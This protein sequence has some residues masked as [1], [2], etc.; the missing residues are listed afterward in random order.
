MGK[1]VKAKIKN[2]VNNNSLFITLL[3]LLLY[4]SSKL[5]NSIPLLASKDNKKFEN[6]SKHDKY[7][8]ST[9]I[10]YYYLFL[11]GFVLVAVSVNA[12]SLIMFDEKNKIQKVLSFFNKF[13]LELF[14]HLISSMIVVIPLHFI[15][16]YLYRYG[17]IDNRLINF[18]EWMN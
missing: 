9:I 4:I 15:I 14:P 5:S 10:F 6:A 13:A 11:F 16:F 8:L 2:Y 17:Y 7:L 3:V 12:V 1:K 18:R